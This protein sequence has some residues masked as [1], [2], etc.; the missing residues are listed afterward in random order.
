MGRF[1]EKLVRSSFTT[2]DQSV[3][4]VAEPNSNAKQLWSEA[5]DRLAAVSSA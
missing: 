5:K 3:A 1:H 4:E 2:W